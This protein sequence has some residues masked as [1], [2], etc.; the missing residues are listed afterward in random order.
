MAFTTRIFLKLRNFFGLLK[1]SAIA[2]NNDDILKLSGALSF[3]T[4][5]SIAPMLIVT[6]SVGS[7][8]FGRDAIQ[9]HLFGQ[10]NSL[11]GDQAAAEIQDMLKHTSLHKDNMLA[12]IVGLVVFFIGA[13]GIFVEIQS[14]INRIWGLKARPQKGFIKYLVNR[15]LS[16][17][18]VV[19]TGFLMV[20]SLLA[21]TL[22]EILNDR[23]NEFLP[24]TAIIIAITNNCVALMI[25]TILFA[26]IF[27]Y[28]PDSIVKWSDAF[29]GALFT[30]V[31]FLAGKYLIAIYVSRSALAGTYG[32]AGSLVVILL[33]IYYSSVL[34]YFG[35]EFTKLY[36]IRHGHG[37]KANK[38]A[39]RVEYKEQEIAHGQK[40]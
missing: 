23:L 5:F 40:M 31:L 8:I 34:L 13:T 24:N 21:S 36:A 15:V 1:D 18:M 2:S 32:A 37:I 29:V 39:V 28:L 25:I 16:F 14:T 38:F 26:V 17:A 9:G 7:L 33:W 35:A 22:V 20:V 10:I 3:Y 19:S 30:S 12:T 11:V 4:I 6:I 27:K